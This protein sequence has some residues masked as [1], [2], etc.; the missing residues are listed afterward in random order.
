MGNVVYRFINLLNYKVCTYSESPKLSAS[1]TQR[2]TS[3]C[4]DSSM[5]S[6]HK[7]RDKCGPSLK[8]VAW[9]LWKEGR[10]SANFSS[11]PVSPWKCLPP[12]C[13]LKICTE[14]TSST[15]CT[16]LTPR[17]VPWYLL[18]GP[19]RVPLA[20][21]L[22]LAPAPPGCRELEAKPVNN[23]LINAPALVPFLSVLSSFISS[24]IN[25][26]WSS[27]RPHWLLGEL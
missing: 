9:T 24:Q 21:H 7:R 20:Q 6:F 23:L 10:G 19:C 3:S 12:S 15:K 26:V 11:L 1:H 5:L 17:F 22:P 13:P 4:K 16:P 25:P 18:S 8:E 2:A 27:P 14:L